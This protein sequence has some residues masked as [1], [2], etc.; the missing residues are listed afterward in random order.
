MVRITTTQCLEMLL[1]LCRKALEGTLSY[2]TL[3]AAV[4]AAADS[5]LC[6]A[7]IRDL[8]DGIEHTPGKLLS[9]TTDMPKW[10]QTEE[11]RVLYADALVLE[12][13][14]AGADPAT[15]NAMRN[16]LVGIVDERGERVTLAE[17]KA[18]MELL[19]TRSTSP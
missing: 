3:A 17:L 10:V 9:R 4:P 6:D 14:A 5:S 2:E 15:G 13:L 11:Y 18:E 8:W 12:S 16:H 1:Q 19:L 7:V